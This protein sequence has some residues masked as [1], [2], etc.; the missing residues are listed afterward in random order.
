MVGLEELQ[1][2]T[3]QLGDSVYWV[4]LSGASKISFFLI[5]IVETEPWE[6]PLAASHKPCWEHR[7]HEQEMEENYL[8]IS[9]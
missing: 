4:F 6:I 8:C 7:K 3:T 5:A 9:P 2:S 1:R